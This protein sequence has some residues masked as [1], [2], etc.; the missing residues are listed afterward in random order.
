MESNLRKKKRHNNRRGL[1]GK[2]KGTSVGD[3]RIREDTGI[4]VCYIYV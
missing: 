3:G 2:M 4:K 1:I